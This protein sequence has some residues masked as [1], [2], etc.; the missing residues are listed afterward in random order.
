MDGNDVVVWAAR[1]SKGKRLL[2]AKVRAT[3]IVKDFFKKPCKKC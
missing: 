3:K 1:K 2:K